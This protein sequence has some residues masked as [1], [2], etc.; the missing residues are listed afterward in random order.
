[1]KMRFV[2]PVVLVIV[3]QAS[4]ASCTAAKRELRRREVWPDQ[5]GCPL[6]FSARRICRYRRGDGTAVLN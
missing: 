1:M 3:P 4:D 5:N 6:F 2:F